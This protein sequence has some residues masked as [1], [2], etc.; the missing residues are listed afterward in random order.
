[1]C[2]EFA[3]NDRPDI[4]LVNIS[5]CI[6]CECLREIWD[7]SIRATESQRSKLP[8]APN[9]YAYIMLAVILS[10]IASV[11]PTFFLSI[12][13]IPQC[14]VENCLSNTN[15]N[16]HPH[17]FA[18]MLV[19]PQLTLGRFCRIGEVIAERLHRTHRTLYCCICEHIQ[20]IDV[21]HRRSLAVKV[22]SSV[23]CKLDCILAGDSVFFERTRNADSGGV[24]R[25]RVCHRDIVYDITAKRLRHIGSVHLT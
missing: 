7:R 23:S 17:K 13:I 1:M 21:W 15:R 6:A 3:C 16:E 24:F 22:Y 14:V 5:K 18:L 12:V 25:E 10:K 20:A 11:T 9:R 2:S 4:A 19:V 8:S